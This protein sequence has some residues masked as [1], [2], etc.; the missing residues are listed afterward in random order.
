MD[1]LSRP[2]DTTEGGSG[3]PQTE[4]GSGD[5]Q[6]EGGSGDPG[7]EMLSGSGGLI[8]LVAQVLAAL[9]L[10]AGNAGTK[11][12]RVFLL[13]NTLNKSWVA[14]SA[15]H[16]NGLA[17]QSSCSSNSLGVYGDVGERRNDLHGVGESITAS[18]DILRDD[19]GQDH[20]T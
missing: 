10:R 11:S 19:G 6:T 5:L 15:S 7:N 8:G 3:D 13:Q 4:G 2:G 12:G 1:S 14:S 18:M 17:A 20:Q 9:T 16:Q